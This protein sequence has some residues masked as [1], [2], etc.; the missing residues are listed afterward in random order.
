MIAA[1]L[2][3]ERSYSNFYFAVRWPYEE[4]GFDEQDAVVRMKALVERARAMS[5]SDMALMMDGVD[6]GAME[7]QLPQ[8]LRLFERE[9]PDVEFIHTNIEEYFS[10][11]DPAVLERMEGPLYH[12]GRRGLNNQLLKNVLSSMV[13]IK[14]ENDRCETDLI[15]VA[16]PLNAFCEMNGRKLKSYNR[17]DYSM[18]PRGMYLDIAWKY[19]ITNHPH[20]SICGCSLSEVH[21]DN[22]YRFRQTEQMAEIAAQDCVNVIARNIRC[23]GNHQEAVFLFNPAQKPVDG[24]CVFSLTV[25]AQEAPNR[26]FYDNENRQM[27]VQILEEREELYSNEKLYQL[28][29]FERKTRLTVA[30]DLKIPAFGYTVI[31]CDH[32]QSVYDPEKKSYGH[33]VYYPPMRFRG[34]QMPSHNRIDNGKLVVELNK[35]GLLNVTR[36]SDGHIFRDLHL[37]E[38]RSDVGEGWNWRPVPCDGIVYNENS[39]MQF[40]VLADGPLCTVWK[41]TWFLHL[42]AEADVSLRRRSEREKEQPVTT[43]LTVP[44]DSTVLFFRT[45]VENETENHRLRVLFPTGFSEMDFYTKTPFDLQKWSVMGEDDSDSAEEDTLVH[46]SQGIMRIGSDENPVSLYTKGLYEVEVTDNEEKALALT[47]FRA[48]TGETGTVHPQDIKMQR[49]LTFE[50]ALSF[51]AGSK[52]ETMLEG[53]AY[54]SGIREFHM[55]QNPKAETLESRSTFLQLSDCQKILSYISERNGI[56]TLRLYDVS[57]IAETVSVILPGKISHV[58]YTDLKGDRIEQS[59]NRFDEKKSASGQ[60][61]IFCPPHKIVTVQIRMESIK[62]K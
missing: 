29:R 17:N 39:P 9:I 20:D 36:K 8:M 1:K 44:K 21:R 24:V 48:A 55:E 59:E 26:R 57:G 42:P 60:V 53:E 19:L 6:H 52:T 5:V 62:V 14:Q 10:H 50:H 16:E 56:Y 3:A 61:D 37:M 4:N 33:Q 15:T 43:V 35:K 34:S 23:T 18:A 11:L 47:L 51:S 13:H 38:D 30:A 49:K 12:L 31:Y 27:N 40:Q 22:E 2:E 25:V 41:L 45:E 32:L 46:P 28:I 54:R 7:P 58:E